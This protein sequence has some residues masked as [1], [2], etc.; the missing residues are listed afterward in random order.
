MALLTSGSGS[1]APGCTP[2]AISPCSACPQDALA[3]VL[4]LAARRYLDPTVV[5]ARRLVEGA[6]RAVAAHLDGTVEPAE[7]HDTTTTL[8]LRLPEAGGQP[9]A[10]LR[11]VLP[12][13]PREEEGE[14]RAWPALAPL[15]SLLEA[16]EAEAARRAPTPPEEGGAQRRHRELQ[17]ALLHGALRTLDRYC[18]ASTGARRRALEHRYRGTMAGV[19]LRVGRREGALRVLQSYTG[20]GAH[21]AGVRAGDELLAVDGRSVTGEKL[22]VVLGWLRGE[23]DT[24]VRLSLR[25][26]PQ[27]LRFEVTRSVFRVPHVRSRLLADGKVG[28][29]GL[30]HMSRGGALEVGKALLGLGESAGLDALILDLRGNSGGS[31]LAAAGTADLFV[32]RGVLTQAL[33]R[34]DRPVRGLTARIEATPKAESELSMAVLVD[35][36]TASSSE[37]LA[38]ALVWNDRAL[39]VGTPTFGKTR[40]LKVYEY[41]EDDLSVRLSVATMRAAGRPLPEQG[42]TPDLTHA[43]L[44]VPPDGAE[45]ADAASDALLQAVA[46]T[47]LA[48]GDPSREVMLRR[49]SASGRLGPRA[50]PAT[51]GPPPVRPDRSL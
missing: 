46:E 37:L 36:R 44:G 8:H 24:R 17:A 43:A 12:A 47:L 1:P 51:P 19:G 6:T 40:V 13:A 5:D 23:P 28:W 33:D 30:S 48:V 10:E 26:G 14:E 2:G 45:G 9:G 11:V 4:C 31:M 18:K 50:T 35:A 21:T 7:V 41:P 39:L 20:S 16:A 29:I 15:R 32:R 3:R 27:T 42:L 49:L 38:G 25:R 34:L 22:S